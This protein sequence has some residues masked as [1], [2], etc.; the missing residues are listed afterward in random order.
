MA[1]G[2][3]PNTYE[4]A[5]SVKKEVSRINGPLPSEAISFEFSW[6]TACLRYAGLAGNFYSPCWGMSMFS[7]GGP[8]NSRISSS[9]VG[10]EHGPAWAKPRFVVH[11][12]CML[13]ASAPSV[14][15]EMQCFHAINSLELTRPPAPNG[16]LPRPRA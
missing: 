5:A 10:R 14:W 4:S 2:G 13:T 15:R 7:R 8:I 11:I 1:S 12:L 16:R 3:L 6:S 9:H